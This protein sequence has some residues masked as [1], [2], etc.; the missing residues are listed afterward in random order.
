MALLWKKLAKANTIHT[1][2]STVKVQR[3]QSQQ[4]WVWPPP[5]H[6]AMIRGP[7]THAQHE[8]G[9]LMGIVIFSAFE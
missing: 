7:P 9:A 2:F 8:T 4:A 6:S 5:S 1:V 3:A